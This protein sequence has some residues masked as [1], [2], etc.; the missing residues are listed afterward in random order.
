MTVDNRVQVLTRVESAMYPFKSNVRV[1]SLWLF[2]E[3]IPGKLTVRD[4]HCI[5]TLPPLRK[6]NDIERAIRVYAITR[7]W[8][9][10]DVFGY[11]SFLGDTDG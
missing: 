1:V 3:A 10:Y 11:I 2:P 5:H 9:K 4:W 6:E 7:G 8:G